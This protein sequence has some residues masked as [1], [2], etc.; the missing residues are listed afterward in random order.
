MRTLLALLA[1]AAALAAGGAPAADPAAARD[2]RRL[3]AEME[4]IH[5]NLFH[6]VSRTRFRRAAADLAARA[7]RLGRDQLL[8]ELMRLVAMTGERDG[9]MGLFPLAPAHR[10]PLHL[11]PVRVWAFPDGFHVLASPE[12]P[13]LV[14]A[15]IVAIEGVPVEEVAAK[16]RPLVTRDN[17][18]SLLL[19]LPEF[20][21]TTEVLHGLGIAPDATGARLTVERA[22]ERSEVELRALA[23]PAYWSAIGE[24]WAPPAP[25]GVPTPLWLRNRDRTQWTATLDRGRAVYAAYQAVEDATTLGRRLVRLARS[26]KVRR[27][28]VDVRLNGG[29]DNTTYGSLIGALR[30]P[31]I[32][33]RGELVLLTGRV[34]FSAAGNFAAE[35]KAAT[36]ARIVGEPA[37]GSPHNYGDSVAVELPSLGWT[38]YVP[39]QYV[40]VLGR[41]DER[42]ELR[43]DVRVV[44]TSADHFVGRDPVLARALALR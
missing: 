27:V 44:P 43:P 2:V 35:V 41:K 19:R 33:R 24:I 9:H 37:G 30:D 15:R 31:A 26:P 29:G 39:P 5:P 21:I 14:G 22:G 11:L 38:V 6:H 16:V 34:T 32:N 8:V 42:A 40:E 17:E 7:P 3:A 10:R 28:I 25:P 13:E 4:R 23:G 36:R 18:S 1:L 12:R 20:M